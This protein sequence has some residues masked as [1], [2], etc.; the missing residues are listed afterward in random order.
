LIR[1]GILK[2]E[3]AKVVRL[4]TPEGALIEVKKAEIEERTT[5]KSAMPEDLTKHLTRREVR[6]LVEFLASLKEGGKK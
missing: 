1:S 5:G 3:D 6:D 2:S 4:M